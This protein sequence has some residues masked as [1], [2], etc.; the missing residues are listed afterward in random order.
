MFQVLEL[1]LM[2]VL[3]QVPLPALQLQP[4][5][6]AAAFWTESAALETGPTAPAQEP[7]M[8]VLCLAVLCLAMLCMVAL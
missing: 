6:L 8:A 4:L 1:M 3:A 7:P 2:L 5:L